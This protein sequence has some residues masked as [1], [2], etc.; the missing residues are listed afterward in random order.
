MA[1]M[2]M[3]LSDLLGTL[4]ASPTTRTRHVSV[5]AAQP[6]KKAVIKKSLYLSD[7]GLQILERIA[8]EQETSQSK[9]V[10]AALI[11]YGERDMQM[12]QLKNCIREALDE[13]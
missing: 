4:M 2:S 5:K 6:D 3:R 7:R 8:N 12:E 13:L 9:V 11:F 1:A 10:N